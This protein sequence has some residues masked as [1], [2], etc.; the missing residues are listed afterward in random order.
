MGS[1]RGALERLRL[2][3]TRVPSA[4]QDHGLAA[5]P[6]DHWF[7]RKRFF[8]FVNRGQVGHRFPGFLFCWSQTRCQP[9]QRP[10]PIEFPPPAGM[11]PSEEPDAMKP[12]R[13]NVLKKPANDFEGLQVNMVPS[14]CV[15]VAVMPSPTIL[16]PESEATIGRGG[17]ENIAAQ[18]FQSRPPRPDRAK[19]H[20]PLLSPYSCRDAGQ[21]RWIFPPEGFGKERSEMIG[22]WPLGQEEL[23]P[24]GEPLTLIVAQTAPGDEVM[25]VRVIDQSAAPGVKD[26]EHPECR[27]QSLWVAGQILQGTGAGFKEKTIPQAGM[28]TNP[29]AQRFWHREG[30]QEVTGGQEQLG[31]M[32]Q[33]SLGVLLTAT[34]TMPVVAGMIGVVVD[35]TVR[36]PVE[37]ASSGGSAA[38]ENLGQDLTLTNGHGGAK[39][40]Q[41]NRPPTEQKLMELDRLA[42]ARHRGR[43]HGRGYRSAMN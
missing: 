19:I 25:N 27:P 29:L 34:G 30:D 1:W 28:G 14:A 4:D 33:P 32:I 7:W 24:L 38:T 10:N 35:L 36:A 9:Q 20:D 12:L 5:A 13:E 15:A 3:F 31:M 17:L 6:T 39:A 40:L 8:Q 43:A 16:G 37:G 42:H 22:H 26:A 23:T 2:R 41:I 21:R 11:K 18:V